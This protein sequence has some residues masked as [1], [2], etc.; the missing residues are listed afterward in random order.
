M[1]A[2]TDAAT[3]SGSDAAFSGIAHLA[4]VVRD[5]ETSVSWY[6]RVLGFER[7]GEVS[8]GPV[9]AG[10]PRQPMRHRASGIVLVIHE[11]IRRSNDLFDPQRTGL[12]HVSLAVPT[13]EQIQA[14]VRRFDE[15]RIDHSGV[16]DFGYARVVTLKD[17][18][19][20]AWELWHAARG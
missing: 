14:W 5:M 8:P 6:E 3:G 9:E 18:D 16:R 1:S 15:L 11:P 2:M 20:I 17:P 13:E 10:H 12:D 19:G 4:I 7:A